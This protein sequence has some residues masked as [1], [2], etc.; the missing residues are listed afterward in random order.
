MSKAYLSSALLGKYNR[1]YINFE[2]NKAKNI[3][4]KKV[5]SCPSH[6]ERERERERE[7]VRERERE[8][9]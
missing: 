3:I 4:F 6:R 1:Q 5:K 2:I 7:R 8:R 9:V